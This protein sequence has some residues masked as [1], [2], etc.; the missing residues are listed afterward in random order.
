VSRADL[1][2]FVKGEIAN[3]EFDFTSGLAIGETITGESCTAVVY[4]G[5]DASP[6]LLI[7]GAASTSGAFVTQPIDA[8]AGGVEGVIY[9]LTCEVTTSDGQTLRQS[10][11]LAILPPL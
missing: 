3:L 10:G 11:Y 9:N 6:A 1:P 2:T 7:S 4:S 5:T 8:D